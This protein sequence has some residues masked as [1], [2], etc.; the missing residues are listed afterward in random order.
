MDFSR[1]T[2]WFSDKLKDTDCGFEILPEDASKVFLMAHSGPLKYLQEQSEGKK[3]TASLREAQLRNLPNGL[4]EAPS[5]IGSDP[6]GKVV[7]I[8]LRPSLVNYLF[9]SSDLSPAEFAQTFT[10]A[11]KLGDMKADEAQTS[12]TCTTAQGVKITIDSEKDVSL[13]KVTAPAKVKAAFD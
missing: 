10:E 6:T 13:E 5:F 12:W 1:L 7:V 2:A 9:R 8:T 11:Y 3:V 4:A